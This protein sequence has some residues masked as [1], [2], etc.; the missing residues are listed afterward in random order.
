MQYREP[1]F[2]PFDQLGA[3]YIHT[4]YESFFS[5]VGVGSF[6]DQTA[7]LKGA[8]YSI[9]GQQEE[10]ENL[11]EKKMQEVFG[12]S[13]T[14]ENFIA[15][16]K[17]W[18]VSLV[19]TMKLI[20]EDPSSLDNKVNII[21]LGGLTAIERESDPVKVRQIADEIQLLM[22]ALIKTGNEYVYKGYIDET[23]AYK[24]RGRMESHFR[25]L[26]SQIGKGI[27]EKG[28]RGILNNFRGA[29]KEYLEL[30]LIGATE[31][32]IG[33][34]IIDTFRQDPS[35]TIEAVGG[36]SKPGADIKRTLGDFSYGFN[37]K[38]TAYETFE[39]HGLHLYR[40]TDL[41]NLFNH[42]ESFLGK[43]KSMEAFKYY[44]INTS[45]MSS[46]PL[47]GQTGSANITAI[48]EG[49]AL[50]QQI[51]RTYTAL[52]I[53]ED[54][55]EI[56]ESFRQADFLVLKDRIYRKSTILRNVMEKGEGE[57][58]GAMS[59]LL[60]FTSPTS[61]PSDGWDRFDKRKVQL[62]Q[63]TEGRYDVVKSRGFMRSALDAVLSRTV[64]IKLNLL[65]LGKD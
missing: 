58:A 9:L 60:K 8:A 47:R 2:Y 33:D 41:N 1:R 14:I 44:I 61:S 25:S 11:I 50:V 48:P 28:L 6:G 29:L 17:N 18:D 56:P 7:S 49:Q 55:P 43:N 23:S 36:E 53:G 40:P 16:Y 4:S 31:S 26:E 27:V 42:M 22:D 46:F 19:K 38:A 5:N 10:R 20:M 3:M 57:G 32:V 13:A 24:L 15:F 54:N 39:K 35:F 62:M 12:E 52:F 21:S 34:V 51:M 30:I 45:R 64:E 63:W 65:K 37:I 59:T